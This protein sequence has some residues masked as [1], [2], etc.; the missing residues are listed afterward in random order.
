MSN[1]LAIIVLGYNRADALNNVLNSLAKLRWSGERIP[2]IVSI[3]N[4]G[5]PEVNAVAENYNWHLGEKRIVIHENRLGLKA[6]FMYSGDIT[7]EF[8]NV[9]F[10][11]DDLLVSPYMMD[12]CMSYISSYCDDDRIAGAS[13]YN[14]ILKEGTGCKFYQIDDGSDV[15]FLQQPY[16]GNIWNKHKWQLFKDWLVSYQLDNSLL[17][18]H[19]AEW[20]DTSFKKV[21]VQY[22]IETDRYFVTPRVS[23]LTNNAEAGVHNTTAKYQFQCPMV[24]GTKIYNMPSMDQSLAVYDAF[25]ELS[26]QVIKKVNPYF[27]EYDFY[28]DIY[29]QKRKDTKYEYCLTSK[30][31]KSCIKEY[32]RQMKPEELAP[33]LSAEGGG[34]R[35]CKTQDIDATLTQR[36]H[37]L[38]RDIESNYMIDA[39]TL[40]ELLKKKIKEKFGR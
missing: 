30:E 7:E 9:I 8:E 3:D 37:A 17:P 6:H 31:A 35:F 5:T 11:E 4:G 33:L 24:I 38:S 29:G 39:K 19:I 10:L 1:K 14:P 13:L 18:P 21:F 12:F 23:V 26:P 2:L 32:S 40:M 36:Q 27:S 15:Y 28:V 20:K 34:L 16:W 25:F 22:L